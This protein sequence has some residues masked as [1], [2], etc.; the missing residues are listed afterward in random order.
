ML[1]QRAVRRALSPARRLALLSACA[2]WACAPQPVLRV[3]LPSDLEGLDPHLRNTVG[4]YQALSHVYEPLVTLDRRMRPT[5][6]LASSWQSPDS[7]NWVFRLRRGVRFHDGRPLTSADV[8]FSLRRLLGDDRL[9]VR[10]FLGSVAE[11]RAPDPAQVLV[12][13][14]W[15]NA[16]LASRLHFVLIVPQG[17]TAESLAAQPNGTGPYR[18]AAAWQPGA[19]LVLRAHEGHWGPPPA[20]RQVEL[21]LAIS[22]EDAVRGIATGSLGLLHHSAPEALAAALRSGRYAVQRNAN[23]FLRHL[24]FDVS[25]ERTPFCPADRNPFRSR[26]VR[27]AL[28]LGLDR[29]ALAAAVSDT[30]RPAFQLVPRAVLGH[31]PALAAS[32]SDL[33][34]ARALLAQ[35]GFAQGF[36]V[37]LHRPNGYVR[38]AEEVRRQLGQLGLRVQVVSLPSAEF[39][40]RLDAGELSF[41]IVAS[42]CATGDGLELLES[43]FHSVDPARGLGGANHGGF[44]DP[45]LDERIRAAASTLDVSSRQQDVQEM[46]AQVLGERVW[47]PLYHDQSQYLVE[48]AWSYTPR[49]DDYFRATDVAPAHR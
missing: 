42:G 44:R 30:A 7:V 3:A 36:E 35:A 1:E 6:A 5:P 47:I 49:D 27:E 34:R 43:S 18:V 12:R 28:A 4:A 17:S 38:A 24:A 33:A 25:R 41:W 10:S 39:F 22:T 31:D 37:V 48:R 21:E 40:R 29:Q 9:E 13:T 15:P 8:A 20:V 26:E 11:V 23:I 45:Q 32:G 14:K 19:P 16:L 46:L 2:S